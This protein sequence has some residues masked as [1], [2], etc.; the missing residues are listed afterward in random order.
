MS[1][2]VGEL[3][4]DFTATAVVNKAFEEVTLSSFRGKN[5]ILFFWPLD[6][7]FVCPTEI[8][9]FSDA[10]DRFAERSTALL[11][12][13]TDSQYTHL[14]WQNTPRSAGGLGQVRFPMVA[15]LNHDIGRS[16]G[17]LIDEQGIAL[18]GLFLIDGAGVIRHML[19]NDLPLGRSVPEA[20][21]M[22]DALLHFEKHGEVCPA[23][24]HAGE[25]GMVPD[26]EKARTF[27]EKWGTGA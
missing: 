2:R 13:S 18:R 25:A 5:V 4:P 17:V 14:A 11:G 22:V 1:A 24:W 26:L 6:F 21:R 20:L 8:C 15:D 12:V 23:N 10:V 19:I 7:T 9:A 16:Y 27:F 3:A